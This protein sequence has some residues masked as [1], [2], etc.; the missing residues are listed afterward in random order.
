MFGVPRLHPGPNALFE[1]G[2]YAVGDASVQILPLDPVGVMVAGAG[3]HDVLLFD[4]DVGSLTRAGEPTQP[5]RRKGDGASRA[6][7]V[8]VGPTCIGSTV[9]ERLALARPVRDRWLKSLFGAGYAGVVTSG[10]Q[11]IGRFQ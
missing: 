6:S 7:G 2:H 1:I 5:G 3:D 10:Q 9:T 8:L 11:I 4:V